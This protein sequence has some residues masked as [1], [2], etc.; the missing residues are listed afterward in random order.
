[1]AKIER[2]RW[3][4]M[5]HW[6]TSIVS[7][8]VKD[9]F[10]I[11]YSSTSQIRVQPSVRTV[12]PAPKEHFRLATPTGEN[13]PITLVVSICRP[14]WSQKVRKLVGGGENTSSSCS[15]EQIIDTRKGMPPGLASRSAIKCNEPL[16]MQKY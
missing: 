10:N 14:V 7:R 5:F 15:L 3:R 6:A 9:R 8:L 13:L 2:T 12:P 1:M 16:M 4:E 11:K